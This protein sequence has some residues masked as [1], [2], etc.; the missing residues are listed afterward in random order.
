TAFFAGAPYAMTV[1]AWVVTGG[2][3][4]LK[5]VKLNPNVSGLAKFS[6]PAATKPSQVVIDPFDVVMTHRATRDAPITVSDAL[7][8]FTQV[9][10]PAHPDWTVRTGVRDQRKLY[11]GTPT[12]LPAMKPVLD[13]A[14]FTVEG[15]TLTYDGTSIDLTNGGAA[16]VVTMPDGSQA[17]VKLGKVAHLKRL[18]KASTVVLDRLG[19]VLRAK[20]LVRTQGHWVFDL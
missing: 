19:H 8:S 16:A 3:G 10:D 1:E 5:T 6:I 18:G 13:A 11:V 7:G 14:G 17:A 4:E 2:K 12:G 20:T 15:N 9:L